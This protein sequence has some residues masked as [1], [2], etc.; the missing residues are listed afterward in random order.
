MRKLER[1]SPLANPTNRQNSLF[2]S[3]DSFEGSL[4]SIIWSQT[5]LL[6]SLD[7]NFHPFLYEYIILIQFLKNN[8]DS[9]YKLSF[10]LILDLLN[11]N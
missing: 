2:L 11:I 3:L 5:G 7:Q 8:L 6:S 10:E 1:I 4:N 9:F